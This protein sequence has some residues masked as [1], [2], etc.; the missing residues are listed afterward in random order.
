M[1]ILNLKTLRH[2]FM[3]FS[4]FLFGIVIEADTY[5]VDVSLTAIFDDGV[6]S[7]SNVLA[8]LDF[9]QTFMLDQAFDQND[10]EYVYVS[11]NGFIEERPLSALYRVYSKTDIELMFAPS[12]KHL[13]VFASHA[14]QVLKVMYVSDLYEITESDLPD[15]PEIPNYDAVSTNVSL[16]AYT[17]L[18]SDGTNYLEPIRDHMIFYAQYALRVDEN[19]TYT[20]SNVTMENLNTNTMTNEAAFNDRV[21]LTADTA[22]EGFYFAYFKDGNDEIISYQNPFIMTASHDM[23]VF[24]V[25]VDT[26]VSVQNHLYMSEGIIYGDR[27]AYAAQSEVMDGHTLVEF[28]FLYGETDILTMGGDGV[29]VSKNETQTR[30]GAFSKSFNN[31]VTYV[32]PYMITSYVV[33]DV[34]TYQTT[35]GIV[36]ETKLPIVETFDTLSSVLSTSLSSVTYDGVVSWSITSG[37]LRTLDGDALLLNNNQNGYIVSPVFEDTV[38]RISVTFKSFNGSSASLKLFSISGSNE[39]EIGVSTMVTGSNVFTYTWENVSLNQ[40]KLVNMTN[41]IIIDNIILEGS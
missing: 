41:Y 22:A 34:I 13:V 33:G 14:G 25:Y 4:V 26:P 12:N 35:Y 36:R 3:L 6:S 37:A 16:D 11:V 24:A 20:L 40:F 9:Q 31:T 17:F 39:V 19:V 30:D 1:R 18:A 8:N 21:K 7:T 2:G 5:E 32:R 27:I 15:V 29:T 38:T 10:Y 23:D 28:G